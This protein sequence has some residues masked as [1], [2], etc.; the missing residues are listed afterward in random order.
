MAIYKILLPKFERYK[1]KKLVILQVYTSSDKHG[2][3]D[4]EIY[5]T[6][7]QP[8]EIVEIKHN[9][10]IDKYL[11]FDIAKKIQHIKIDRIL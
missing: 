3:G 1:N 6:D 2:F 4:I 10:P 8:F 11:I 9:I 7:N 5:T